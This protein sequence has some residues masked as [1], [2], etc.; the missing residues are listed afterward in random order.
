HAAPALAAPALAATA[1]AATALLPTWFDTQRQPRAVDLGMTQTAQTARETPATSVYNGETVTYTLRLLNQSTSVLTDVVV[2]DLLPDDTLDQLVC[3]PACEKV[4]DQ[5]IIPEP[6]GGAVVVTSTRELKWMFPNLGANDVLTLTF[7]GRVIGQPEGTI[8]TNRAF[9]S[10]FISG[11]QGAA[12]SNDLD[13]TALIRAQAGGGPS[14][15]S[16]ATWFSDDAGGTISQDWGDFDRDGDLDLA[17]GAS[18]GASIYRNEHGS[19]QLFWQSPEGVADPYRLSYG[20]RWAD[21]IPDAQDYLELVVVGESEDRSATSQGLNYIYQ[22][23]PLEKDFFEASAF[24]SHYQLVRV[25]PGDFDG[26]G[27]LDLIASTNAI[28]G[29]KETPYQSLCPVNLYRNDGTGQFTGTVTTQATQDVVCLSTEA[30]AA[31]ETG[32]YDDDG[33]LDVIA[34][35]FPSNLRLFING[36]NGAVLT[37]T[38]PFTRSRNLEVGLEYLPYD[39]AW[40]DFDSDGQL[41]LA[42]AFPIQ[43][44]VHI[45]RNVGTAAQSV[46]LVRT[47]AFMTP[48]ALDW[49][50][51]DGD[52]RVDLAV[53]DAPP[54]FY[55]YDPAADG[56]QLINCLKLPQ[57]TGREQIWS[58][59]GAALSTRRNLDLVLS[60]R[61]GPSQIFTVLSPRLSTTF[62][63]VSSRSASSVAWGDADG[64]G[65]LDLLLGS[66][67]LPALSAYIHLND[68]GAFPSAGAH[69]FLPS[70]FGPHAVA[71]GDVDG[72]HRLEVAIGTPVK[73]QVYQENVYNTAGWKIDTTRAVRSLAWGDANDDEALDLLVGYENG[74]VELYLNEGARLSTTPAF[75]TTETGNARGLA[76]GDFD[77]DHYLDFAVA[78]QDGP[79]RVYRN[80]GDAT[81]ALSWQSPITQPLANRAMAWGDYDADG[82]LDLAIGAYGHDDAIWENNN[83]AFGIQPVWTAG[84]P[85]GKTTGL[86]W[87][88]WDHDGYLDLAV[89]R[90]NEPDVVYANLGSQPGLPRLFPV[91]SSPESARTTGIAWGDHDGDGDLD[92][93][94]SRD[95]GAGSGFYQNSLSTAGHQPNTPGASLPDSPPYVVVYRPGETDVA[96]FYSDPTIV[97][98][99]VTPTLTVQYRV[100]D[101]E[102]NHLAGARFEYSLDGGTLW[103]TATP[104]TGNSTPITQTSPEGAAGAF[105]WNAAADDAVS[106]NARFRVSVYESNASGP[107]QDIGGSAI[108]PPFRVRALDCFWPAGVSIEVDTETPLTQ[109]S[110]EFIARVASANGPVTYAWDFGD[111]YTATGWKT[112]HTFR[113]SGAYLVTLKVQGPA[114][115]I[116]RPAYAHLAMAVTGK[117]LYLPQVFNASQGMTA[118]TGLPVTLPGAP[119]AS[120]RADGVTMGPQAPTLATSS[121]VPLGASEA[122]VQDH[123]AA[124]DAAFNTL[125]VTN[126]ALGTNHQPV[127]NSDGTRIAFWSTGRLTGR[128]PDGN[129]EIFLATIDNGSGIEY[130]QITSS[131]G[132]ILGGF[133]L[134]PAINGA[135]DRIVFFSDRDLVEGENPDHNFEIFLAEVNSAGVPALHQVTATPRG[136]NIMPD[137]SDDGKF[138]AFASDNDLTQSG[139]QTGGLT[140]IFRAKILGNGNFTFERVTTS[141]A[142]AGR[143]DDPSINADGRFIA[144][145]SDQDLVSSGRFPK[146]GNPDGNREIFVAEIEDNG[147]I[148]YTQ[149]TET[150][151]STNEQPAISADGTRIAYLSTGFDSEGPRQVFLAEID[152]ATQQVVDVQQITHD[153]S[154]KNRPSLSG[155]GLRVAYFSEG[156]R[157]VHVYDLVEEREIED[158]GEGSAYPALSTGGTVMAYAAG[159][160]IYLKRYS[161]VDLSVTKVATP[162]IVAAGEAVT[163]TLGVLNAGPSPATDAILTDFLPPGVASLLPSAPDYTQVFAPPLTPAGDLL[164]LPDLGNADPWTDMTGNRLLLHLDD[165]AGASVFVDTSGQGHPGVCTGDACPIAGASGVFATA[166]NFDGNND[167]VQISGTINLANNAFTI[168]LWAKRESSG[169]NDYLISQGQSLSNQGLN[170][171][172]RNSDHFTCA[173]WNNDLDTPAAYPDTE[174][175]HW[176]CTYDPASGTRVIYRDG[177]EVAR[178]TA[179]IPYQGTG[180]MRLGTLTGNTTFYFLGEMDEVA[181]FSRALDSEAILNLAN[182]PAV[183]EGEIAQDV[184]GIDR[185]GTLA[186]SPQRVVNEA[187]P[188]YR[189]SDLGYLTGTLGIANMANTVLLLH[190]DE[191]AGST[192]FLDTS[193]IGNDGKC[194]GIACPTAGDPGRFGGALPF[195]GEND[196]INLGPDA[197]LIITDRLTMEGWVFPT[198]P[199][200]SATWGG[201]LLSKEGEYEIARAFGGT[202]RWA[203]TDASNVRHDV[204]TGAALPTHQWSHIAVVF[205][206][207]D[208]R[209]YING[210]LVHSAAIGTSRL[211]DADTSQNDA[212]VGA[213]QGA[214]YHFQG[215]IDE[216][217]LFKRVLSAGEITDHYLRGALDIAFQVRGCTDLSSCT[218][219]PFTGPLGPATAFTANGDG[220]FA[221]PSLALGLFDAPYAHYRILLRSLTP[222]FAPAVLS[223]TLRPQVTCEGTN[224]VECVLGSASS[225]LEPGLPVVLTLPAFVGT[226]AFFSATAYVGEIPIITNTATIQAQESDHNIDDNQDEAY[227]LLNS[228]PVLG[229]AIA[230]PHYGGAD[231]AATLTAAITPENSSP[232][233]TYTW[234]A[235]DFP[236]PIVR[237]S[238]VTDTQAYT[239]SQYGS[240][241]ITVT[242]D[243]NLGN[244]AT[245]THTL[246]VEIPVSDLQTGNDSP[247]AVERQTTFTAFADGSNVVYLW[248]FGD[249]MTGTVSTTGTPTTPAEITHPYVTEGV[250]TVTVRAGNGFN[251]VTTTGQAIIYPEA[252]LAV[253]QSDIPYDP[254]VAGEALTYTLSVVNHGPSTV[255]G[256]VLT[257]TLPGVTAYVTHTASQGQCDASSGAVICDFGSL[258]RDAQVTATIQALVSPSARGQL[259]NL[260]VVAADQVDLTPGNNAVTETTDLATNVNLILE[261]QA[262]PDPSV[263]AGERLTYTL[264]IYNEGPSNGTGVILTDTLPAGID[265]VAVSAGCQHQGGAVVCNLGDLARDESVSATITTTVQSGARGVLENFAQASSNEAP[266]VEV[267]KDITIETRA[268]LELVKTPAPSPTVVAGMP[269]TYTLTILNHGP[270][271]ATDLIL[272]DTLPAG[273]TYED[274]YGPGACTHASGVVTCTASQISSGQQIAIRL[275]GTVAPT[276]TGTLRNEADV[277]AMEFDPDIADNHAAADISVRAEANLTLDKRADT[278]VLAGES[279]TYTLTV[280][281]HGPSYAYNVIVT[282]TMPLS[283]TYSGRYAASQGSCQFN[284]GVLACAVGALSVDG[285]AAI[286]FSVIVDGGAR[287][288]IEN[289]A[290]AAADDAPQVVA[291]AQTVVGA[292]ATLQ[293]SKQAPDSA[294]AG[295]SLTY[296]LIVTNAGPSTANNVI[297]TD[298]LPSGLAATGYD[299]T[300]GSC[301]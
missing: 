213:R 228:I 271:D 20:V 240:K 187:L 83:G 95:G 217:A 32:D 265:V 167:T 66:A 81:F 297:L 162:T 136:V 198:G 247:T 286:T 75:T 126:Y 172:F 115:P 112:T 272:T 86:A 3:I 273:I 190:F 15:S 104:A 45:Y 237:S 263:V 278:A 16:V 268:N 158:A 260:T 185:W 9:A 189:Q 238:W 274:W 97:A 236:T 13:L 266:P 22:Y 72:D 242:A 130:T 223:A 178:D 127:I 210:A 141:P 11:Q 230:G 78:L 143:N 116:G 64:D 58:L 287:G 109:E 41:D 186:W 281:N 201:V 155:D 93:A 51:F 258:A 181:I 243:N 293:L 108:S 206:A 26:D 215:R 211:G 101:A 138:L 173:F 184:T 245:A 105:S 31:L 36:R 227:T 111:G 62:V 117:T 24:T 76:W 241:T 292:D 269:A 34:G 145:V 40:G 279:L 79:V 251:F 153:N 192:D 1:R 291:Q 82:D 118:T 107:V 70:G 177:Y 298:T 28:N 50:D 290:F 207:G 208:A 225:P 165:P 80:L 233:V 277:A 91:W 218:A 294:T 5:E 47:T 259:I 176:A 164:A 8:F 301:T 204:D 174:W 96:D 289:T 113:Q 220:V 160:D 283:T 88:D 151:G 42:A 250:F 179:P 61:D 71:F 27:D 43:R 29:G 299:A 170:V 253:T 123:G 35:V 106:D 254:V 270:S 235:S 234:Q 159:G 221:S 90:Y 135:G 180:L 59:R 280:Q 146:R 231:I 60:N 18:L 195:D 239:W 169:R 199:G 296:T 183:F 132:T 48:L 37:D 214:P 226:S 87:G 203:F 33:D 56:F 65:A 256:V 163:Y 171:G 142:D 17:L 137:I 77:Q 121:F 196:T 194:D 168:A 149:V 246:T 53:A 188:N 55:R 110:V 63:P 202:L 133:N 275:R 38:V 148:A 267:Q 175:H 94:V 152:A 19:L 156:D 114:C 128:N 6:S 182:R 14:I 255:T 7:S 261:K 244:M 288:Q 89:G 147:D 44:E 219:Q 73:V 161:L 12:S 222:I 54:K 2:V 262:H 119:G 284:S 209:S 200:S 103:H 67:A 46:A 191:P 25:V 52:G 216:L 264:V 102:S 21:L 125:Q 144:F 252:D 193:G 68:H 157:R 205:D 248:D 69:E 4:Y 232:P 98:G 150:A 285:S 120:P 49:G 57:S 197:S 229:V 131:T 134:F 122:I 124:L 276:A 99:P 10:Y 139:I 30:T 74:P 129:I 300:P 166:L 224:V 249:G 84:E 23:D 154:N 39:L 100:Y 85:A 212:R 282:D 295:L 257:D 92:L 140:E